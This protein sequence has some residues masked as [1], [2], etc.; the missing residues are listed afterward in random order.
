MKIVHRLSQFLAVA[1]GLAAAFSHATLFNYEYTFGDGLVVSGSLDGTQ[2]GNFVENISNVSVF[3]NGTAMLGT[4]FTSKYDGSNYLGGPVVSFDAT[5]NNFLLANSDLAAGDFGYDAVF[6]MLN[7][8]VFADTAVAFS[9]QGFASQ[10][11]PTASEKWSLTVPEGGS[12]AVL[13]CAAGVGLALVRRK[14]SP[15][16]NDHCLSMRIAP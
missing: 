16:Q 6:Y 2:S 11:W 9:T 5:K 13:L 7:E 10:D 3:F 8:S 14:L 1:L 15:L 4:V 12:T